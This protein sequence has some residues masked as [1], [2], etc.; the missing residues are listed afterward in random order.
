[1]ACTSVSKAVLGENPNIFAFQFSND[2]NQK[3]ET[4]EAFINTVRVIP[5]I[6]SQSD[7][8]RCFKAAFS[9]VESEKL[10]IVVVLPF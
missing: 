6:N 5:L 1:M 8:Q 3:K 4:N 10:Q 7:S 2:S 9:E